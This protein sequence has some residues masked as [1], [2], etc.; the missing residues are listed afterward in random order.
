MANWLNQFK[1]PG[2]GLGMGS[3][4]RAR[5][6]GYSPAQIA[7]AIPGTK[8]S[9]G[10]RLANQADAIVSSLKQRADA[11][12]QAQDQL[13]SYKSQ[14]DSYQN[15]VSQLQG[16]YNKAMAATVAA[17]KQASEFESKFQKASADYEAARQEAD[18]YREEAVGQQLRALRSGATSSSRQDGGGG[19]GDLAGGRTRFSGDSG[20][21]MSQQAREEA[22][23]TDSVLNRKG[24][25]VERINSG[26][27][28]QAGPSSQ[29][30]RG[31][32]QGAGTGSY[33][34]SR[35]G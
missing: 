31:L 2:G 34:A 9:V 25:V 11:G 4:N 16:Q 30:N 8:L 20:S 14:L 33:Y 15:Q 6:A 10:W 24:P 32:A 21:S 7:A 13:S 1:G 22:G 28:R 23:L 17:Q 27:Q 18:S 12:K 26:N 19:I 35:F 29:P 3:F 5:A